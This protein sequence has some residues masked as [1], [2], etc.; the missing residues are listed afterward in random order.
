MAACLAAAFAFA[1][2]ASTALAA[3]GDRSPD[4]AWGMITET[5]LDSLRSTP[6]TEPWTEPEAFQAAALDHGALIAAL[7]RVPMEFTQAART[8]PATISL[9]RPDGAFEQFG[10]VE[11]PIMEPGL[12]AWLAAE[13]Y[14]MKTYK[15]NSLDN[16]GST[17]RID[18]GGP[19]GLH[20]FINGGGVDTYYINPRWRGDDQLH[21]SFFRKDYDPLKHGP[22][23]KCN[24]GDKEFE[25][26]PNLEGATTLR[27]GT[28]SMRT[29][30]L[31]VSAR[32]TYTNFHGG[33]QA[34]GQ[35]AI[36]TSVNRVNQVYEVDMGL[37][38]LLVA[39]NNL[40]VFTTAT[41]PYTGTNEDT[42]ID[43]CRTQCNNLI[44]SANYDL[45]HL[46]TASANGYGPGN[47][48]SSAINTSHKARGVSGTANPIGDPFSIDYFAH[49]MGHMIGAQHTWNY[50]GGGS[51]HGLS[52][53][54]GSGVTIMGYAG[55]C[56]ADDLASNSI[57]AFHIGSIGEIDSFVV[58]QGCFG[59]I[60]SGNA[61]APVATAP[62]ARSIPANTPFEL[63]ATGG[64]D[65]D[66]DTIT[67]SWEQN[68]N[69]LAGTQ[70]TLAGSPGSTTGPVFRSFLPTTS[71]T[72]VFP[73]IANLVAGGTYPVGSRL[74]TVSRSM[75]FRCTVRDNNAGNGRVSFSSVT[76][77]TVAGTAFAVTAPNG[78]G[79]LSGPTN[80]TWNVVG[81]NAGA[82]N[83]PNVDIFLSTDGGFTYPTTLAT[84]VPNDGS[85]TVILPNI[86]TSTARIKVKGNG[87]YFFDIS[88]ANFSITPGTPTPLFQKNGAETIND[89]NPGFANGNG[90]IEPDEEGIQLTF[91]VQ[92]A[93]TAAATGVAGTLVSLTGTVTVTTANRSWANLGIG[94]TGSNTA[95]FV[96]TVSPA[97]VCGAPINLQLNMTSNEG[98]AVGLSY[99]FPTGMI[100]GGTPLPTQGFEGGV[101]PAGWSVQHATGSNL[102]AVR[103]GGPS[104]GTANSGTFLAS[105]EQATGVVCNSRFVTPAVTGATELTFFHSYAAEQQ[106]AS[107]GY[108]GGLIEISTTGATG[109]W[110]Q[111]S[112]QITAG[113]YTRTANGGFGST[114][115]AGTPFWSGTAA[116]FPGSMS[117]VTVDLSAFSAQNINIA[118]RWVS[119]NSTTVTPGGWVIDDVTI[120]GGTPVCDPVPVEL[121][122]FGLE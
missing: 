14:P 68:D 57:A 10:I 28:S 113:G 51:G 55:L 122:A 87:N 92:N 25:L 15:V 50:C 24:T 77:S 69:G 104:V 91:P 88:N 6:G 116:T 12:A 34:Q 61:N 71:P 38:L 66:G 89:A 46:V 19:F 17:G 49:E 83:T 37:R 53:E 58:S 35:A 75:S 81:T 39:N 72:R 119:D 36:V 67:Y 114:V 40:V 47:V 115:T 56:G 101:T 107:V 11:S 70:A 45:G 98:G 103:N 18:F 102:W 86:T 22:A 13:G 16:P 100:V 94:A 74:C 44:G 9:P 29:L 99:T 60:A 52:N 106:D 63:T 59:T 2:L 21:V 30:R 8:A 65:A 23:W 1:N 110:T 97:H 108:D 31:A 96:I 112:G 121:S 105:Y 90:V 48:C 84:A 79:T 64:M 42:L 85:E 93:G 27:G 118:F 80:V 82:V 41:N 54:P 62:A 4:G 3:P 5:E 120:T 20:A 32:S 117:Q 26:A 95:P 7:S 111:L 43:T 73:P 78:G 109:P 76:I 33:S